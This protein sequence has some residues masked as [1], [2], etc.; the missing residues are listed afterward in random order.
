M[1]TS[2]DY[3]ILV[4]V[5]AKIDAVGT[6]PTVVI[7]KNMYVLDSDDLPVIVLGYPYGEK[8]EGLVF[9]ALT[10]IHQVGVAVVTAANR[11]FST[12]I[13]ADLLL[14]DSLKDLLRGV[15]LTGVSAVWDTDVDPG[16]PIK[17]PTGAG[18]AANHQI[19]TFRVSYKVN[20]AYTRT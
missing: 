17:I 3:D 8:V 2:I 18:G 4:A 16:P 10:D 13:S 20:R 5:K 1:P 19:S 7:R 14:R 9:G 11:D 15:K 6:Y 12:S